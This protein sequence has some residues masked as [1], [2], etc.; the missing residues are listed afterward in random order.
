MRIELWM[1]SLQRKGIGVAAAAKYEDML[2]LTPNQEAAA[3]IEKDISRTFPNMKRFATAEGQEALRRVLLAYAAYDPEVGYCQGLN[4]VAGLLLMYLPERHAFGGLVVLMHDRGLRNY[5]S[6]DMSLLQVSMRKSD[7]IMPL[8]PCSAEPQPETVSA[9]AAAKR[10][11]ASSLSAALVMD[12]IM[13]DKMDQ[14]LLKAAVGLLKRC[15]QRLLDVIDME[16]CLALLKEEM[17]G[18]EE[19]QLHDVLTEAFRSPWSS[20]Q[21]TLLGSHPALIDMSSPT[22]EN[23]E[24]VLAAAALDF[25]STE[26][27]GSL[28]VSHHSTSVQV[29]DDWGDFQSSPTAHHFHHQHQQAQHN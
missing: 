1:S 27:L 24:N 3:D 10:R 19:Q 9:T 11:V 7:R 17:P 15:E 21:L 16:D 29:L 23:A 28:A 8:L 13:A 6:V 5:Y 20:R 25:C 2:L 22:A 4:F 12:V 14:A 18:W 26:E